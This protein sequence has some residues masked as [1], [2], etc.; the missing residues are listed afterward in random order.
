MN[1]SIFGLLSL[2]AFGFILAG[3]ISKDR[4]NNVPG[5]LILLLLG[6]MLV[7]GNGIEYQSGTE[8]IY[9][10]VNGSQEVVQEEY[11]FSSF[12]STSPVTQDRFNTGL[13][14]SY[15]AISM[16][17]FLI[18]FSNIRFRSLLKQK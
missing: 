6:L 14:V 2:L 17:Y 3:A 5:A 4:I 9:G 13:G 16:Y 11:K 12:T 1:L 7:S 15:I 8:L 18:A 10:E